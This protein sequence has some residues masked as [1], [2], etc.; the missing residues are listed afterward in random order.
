MAKTN[1]FRVKNIENET[2]QLKKI[3]NAQASGILNYLISG[4][5]AAATDCP[6]LLDFSSGI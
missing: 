1:K 2:K 5:L 4:R 3:P 6:T